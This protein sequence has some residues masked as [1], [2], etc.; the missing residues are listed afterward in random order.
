M[1]KSV[2][3]ID[4]DPIYRTISHKIIEKLD[5]AETIYVEK[6]G[7]TAIQ[8]LTNMLENNS[9]LPQIIL[10]DIEMPVMNG[11]EFMDEYCKFENT[12]LSGI[13]IYIVS[14]SIS[15]IDKDKANTYSEIKGFI[16][17]PLTIETLKSILA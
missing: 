4:N 5:L 9:S 6:N 16:S 10:L 14:S 15:Q 13:E 2:L 3:I 7:Y 17:K 1:K 12:L 8:F 11:W